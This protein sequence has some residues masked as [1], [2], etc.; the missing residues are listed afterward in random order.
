MMSLSAGAAQRCLLLKITL[1][2]Y[3]I[4]SVPLPTNLDLESVT[5]IIQTP[6]KRSHLQLSSIH[7]T[8][9]HKSKHP[10]STIVTTDNIITP[11][12]S[13][14]PSSLLPPQN[15]RRVHQILNTTVPVKIN[16]NKSRMHTNLMHSVTNVVVFRFH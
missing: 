12:P 15:D 10:S 16:Q 2:F 13:C 5:L 11:S 8:N 6:K 14:Q 4:R 1:T 7:D 9:T 3:S